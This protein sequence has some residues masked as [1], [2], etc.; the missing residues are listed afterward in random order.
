MMRC[1]ALYPSRVVIRSKG[2][3]ATLCRWVHLHIDAM[4]LAVV[5]QRYATA[6]QNAA[7]KGNLDHS[8]A[9]GLVVGDGNRVTARTAAQ[10][11]AVAG[12]VARQA[13]SPFQFIARSE[14]RRVGKECVSTCRSRW[15]PYQYTK[16]KQK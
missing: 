4:S 7:I 8:G 15:S 13:R 14:E 16:K 5:D 1:D 6:G 10:L 11:R 9:V 12:P 3:S 2:R